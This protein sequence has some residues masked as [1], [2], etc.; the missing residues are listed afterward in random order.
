MKLASASISAG[1]RGFTRRANSSSESAPA[2]RSLLFT[3][4]R[5][6]V[7]QASPSAIF[8]T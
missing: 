5:G 4:S 2:P 6:A 3:Q 1:D 8:R 7:V